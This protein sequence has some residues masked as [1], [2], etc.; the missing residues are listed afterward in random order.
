MK[1]LKDCPSVGMFQ[2]VLAQQVLA[3]IVAVRRAHHGVDVLANRDISTRVRERD[4]SFVVFPMEIS[5]EHP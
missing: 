3:V 2:V 4:R 5:L 1:V